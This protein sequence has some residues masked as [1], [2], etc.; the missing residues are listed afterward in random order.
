MQ[1]S[2]KCFSLPEQDWT[3]VARVLTTGPFQFLSPDFHTKDFW[4][5]IE[6][7]CC[8]FLRI[9]LI[10]ATV[11]RGRCEVRGMWEQWA[12]THWWPSQSRKQ[13]ALN[14]LLIENSGFMYKN[15][16][17]NFLANLKRLGKY[18]G[19]VREGMRTQNGSLF[20][21]TLNLQKWKVS[22]IMWIKQNMSIYYNNMYLDKN[23]HMFRKNPFLVKIEY[24][25][26]HWFFRAYDSSNQGLIVMTWVHK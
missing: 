12:K 21:R 26:Y 18:G 22:F 13:S 10:L 6:P 19:K 15:E 2:G 23:M 3:Q 9:K 20:E 4:I 7:Y 16:S 5:S 1:N 17:R 8:S 11:D 14:C 24:H 25:Q